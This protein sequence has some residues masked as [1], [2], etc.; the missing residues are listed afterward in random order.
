MLYGRR[1]NGESHNKTTR[2]QNE[3]MRSVLEEKRRR[4]V[5]KQKS[6]DF[7]FNKSHHIRFQTLT[8]VTNRTS[9]SHQSKSTPHPQRNNYPKKESHGKYGTFQR[10]SQSLKFAI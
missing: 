1:I 6:R 9:Y 5:E 7:E 3:G 4:R 10:N 8:T 2:T